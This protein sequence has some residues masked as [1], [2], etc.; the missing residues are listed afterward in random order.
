MKS[1]TNER[2]CPQ[3]GILSPLL[4]NLVVDELLCHTRDN[5]PCDIQAFADDIVL[6]A[7]GF[8]ADTL[9]E[10]TQKSLNT[11]E[12][13]CT[14]NG[15]KLSTTKTHAIMFTWKRKW[16]LL[17]PLKVNNQT[18][19]LKTNTKFLGVIIDDKLN[20]NEHIKTQTN[21]AIK[22]LNQCRRSLGPTWGFTPQ[23]MKWIYSAMVRPLLCYASVIWIN[24]I[25]TQKNKTQL[26]RVQ[27]LSNIMTTGAMPSTPLVA[28]DRILGITPILDFIEGE[29]AKGAIRIKNS[30][31]WIGL[32]N[33][34]QSRGRL[35]PHSTINDKLINNAGLGGMVPDAIPTEL[36]LDNNFK[37]NIPK[38][39]EYPNILDNQPS[40]QIQCFTDGSKTT[41]GVGAGVIIGK[42]P[43]IGTSTEVSI[44]MGSEST[45]F[46]AE[47]TAVGIAADI[48]LGKNMTN[49]SITILTD[50]Q[51]TLKALQRTKIRS[52]TVMKTLESLNNLGSTNQV[53]LQW[54]PAHSGYT[55]TVA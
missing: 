12:T 47:V 38:R 31:N 16:K 3:G 19:S 10:V 35:T 22:V 39:D 13:W 36:N 8:D 18:I 20:W 53:T 27:R 55:G 30:E 49:K 46:Q 54:I 29:A 21:K 25:K 24:G 6:L 45:V 40:N 41:D 1:I 32:P 37:I 52:K 33:D 14:E 48:L 17:K 28:L 23:T 43:N 5:M 15:L 44:N 7:R 50:S 42:N 11:I 51:A 2:G 34:K 9:R 4:W 26:N